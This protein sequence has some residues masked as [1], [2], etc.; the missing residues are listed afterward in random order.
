[1]L[2]FLSFILLSLILLIPNVAAPDL[3][4]LEEHDPIVINGNQDLIDTASAEGWVGVGSEEFPIVI[5]GLSITG[6]YY[7][8]SITNVDLIFR[9]EECLINGSEGELSWSFGILLDNCSSASVEKST[10]WGFDVGI[11]L[12]NSNRSLVKR[13]E[14]FESFFG[15]F[16][17]Y[18]SSVWLH[19]LDIV[20]CSVGVRLNHTI[21]TTVEQTIID[22]CTYSGIEGI[23][24]SGTLLRHNA[25]IGSEV[26]VAFALNENW[27]IEE[28]SIDSCEVGFEADQTEGGFILRTLIKNCTTTGICL[29]TYSHNV[30]VIE[31][32]LGPGNS[33][34]ALDDGEA[35]IWYEELLQIGNYWSDYS[36]EGPYVIPGSAE[37]VDLYPTSLEDA[38]DW[39]FIVTIDDGQPSDDDTTTNTADDNVL[40]PE[41]LMIAAAST[42]VILLMVAAMLK[43][44]VSSGLS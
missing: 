4:Q 30:T 13:T 25:I 24:D 35:N 12:S 16:V 17:N 1:M 5:K 10:I 8:I 37:S 42:I 31:N 23:F 9:I 22:H 18:S 29:G 32:W 3:V 15:V 27:V 14:V 34:N 44:R 36:G 33:Q 40:N 21:H 39:E 41:T 11:C 38:P 20:M 6:E 43:S 28:S 19:S 2:L 26:G 7:G